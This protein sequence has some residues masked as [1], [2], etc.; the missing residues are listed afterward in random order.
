M[1]LL[2]I[3]LCSCLIILT[4]LSLFA[5]Y[6]IELRSSVLS[7]GKLNLY[8]DKPQTPLATYL[9]SL[10]VPKCWFRHFYVIGLIFS[11]I[12]I[13]ELSYLYY[14]RTPLL[15]ISS[16]QHYDSPGGHLGSVECVVG[17]F[18]L[19]LHILRRTI[20]SLWIERPS[21]SARMNIS[22]Y[23]IGIGFYGAMVFGTWLESD[24]IRDVD[25]NV[26]LNALPV[27]ST[28]IAVVL[29]IY[30]SIHQYRCHVILAS[31]RSPAT[32]NGYKIPRGDWFEWLVTPHYLADI[33]IYL[34]LA[35]LYQFKNSIINCGLLWTLINLSIT[36]NET[37]TWYEEH[38][39]SK[40]R[41]AFPGGRWRIIPYLY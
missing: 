16:I 35:I 17:L 2:V 10:T 5:K 3:F 36:S 12:C 27:L 19:S 41:D 38:F 33:L 21:A 1:F 9:S 29:Y 39:K 14:Y 13:V 18:L 20:E 26:S 15:L 40:Y 37:K 24:L 11:C 22:H 7:Y 4:V 30:A 34:S 23:L 32:H 28:S 25:S 31:L 6:H 8:A